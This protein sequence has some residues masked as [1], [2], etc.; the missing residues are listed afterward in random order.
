MHVSKLNKFLDLEGLVALAGVECHWHKAQDSKGGT[1][2]KNK[3]ACMSW[4]CN[5]VATHIGL[6]VQ[7]VHH[8]LSSNFQ[9]FILK[10]G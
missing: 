7:H 4:L 9:S 2:D 8:Q 1:W 5:F 10:I 3:H 6:D